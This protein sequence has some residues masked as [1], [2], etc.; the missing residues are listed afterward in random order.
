[1]SLAKLMTENKDCKWIYRFGANPGMSRGGI[2]PPPRSWYLGRRSGRVPA[3]P[4]PPPRLRQ[5]NPE[6]HDRANSFS[7]D[8]ALRLASALSSFSLRAAQIAS[9]RPASLS[10]GVT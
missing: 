3:L 6:G 10:A 1:M 2:V 7:L 9:A 4:Y 5:C 8:L